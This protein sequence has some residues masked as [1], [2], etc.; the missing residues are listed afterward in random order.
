MAWETE[1]QHASFRGVLFDCISVSDS[2]S[3]ALAAHQAP[4]SDDAIIEDMGKDAQ[5]IAVQIFLSGSDYLVYL[6]ALETAF[7]L[8]GEGEFI[9]PIHGIKNVNAQ[10]WNVTHNTDTVDGCI[11]DVDFLVAKADRKALFIPRSLPSELEYT[12]V[13]LTPA[14]AL[15]RELEQLKDKDPNLFFTIVNRIGNGLKKARQILGIAR[16]TIDN[17]LSPPTWAVGLIDDVVRL[18]TFEFDDISAISKWRSMIDRVNRVAK[19]FDED[20]ANDSPTFKQLWRSISIASSV[21][22]AQ[23]IVKQTRSE[24][25]QNRDINVTPIDL[26]IVRQQVRKDIQQTIIIEREITQDVATQFNIDPALQVAQYK[27]LANDV[28]DQIQALI[29]TRPPITNTPILLPCTAHWLAHKLYGDMNRAEE[30][31]RLNPSVFNFA[32]LQAGMELITYAR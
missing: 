7:S 17:I 30:I 2:S 5:R 32:T 26:A 28:H 14:A 15:Q 18:A 24:M 13:I 16:S 9:H 23:T 4:Y 22:A 25:A 10:N 12:N 21:A 11:I 20:N 19:I 8:T 29:E 6:N 3:K 1:L 27:T 31:K